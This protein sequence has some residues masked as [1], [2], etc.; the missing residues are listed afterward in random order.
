MVPTSK[1]NKVESDV[2]DFCSKQEEMK[3]SQGLLKK[4]TV[5]E[6]K[7]QLPTIFYFQASDSS[8]SSYECCRMC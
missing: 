7:Y 6:K 4:N 5:E 1:S 2:N 8:E 3:M